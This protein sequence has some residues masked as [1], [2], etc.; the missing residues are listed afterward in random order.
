MVTKKWADTGVIITVLQT[1]REG[2]KLPTDMPT[3]S[4]EPNPTVKGCT[5]GNE[6]T[7]TSDNTLLLTGIGLSLSAAATVVTT[8]VMV[9]KKK[10]AKK[11]FI[12]YPSLCNNV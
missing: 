2:G 8:A 7:N 11:T 1:G 3:N 12:K 10:K 6:T 5:A 9:K 4:T